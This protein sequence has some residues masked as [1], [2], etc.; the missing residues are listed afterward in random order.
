M[1]IFSVLFQIDQMPAGEEQKKKMDEER[2][3]GGQ[4]YIL[5]WLVCAPW[6]TL[7]LQQT[8]ASPPSTL[9]SLA[10]R[11]KHL[12]VGVINQLSRFCLA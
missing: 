1:L 2:A 8:F 10:E 12:D 6:Q 5:G 9:G 11:P 3:E 4:R 7:Q